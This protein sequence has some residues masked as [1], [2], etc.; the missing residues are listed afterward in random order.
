MQLFFADLYLSHFSRRVQGMDA[1]AVIEA[2]GAEQMNEAAEV[3]Y[4]LKFFSQPREAQWEQIPAFLAPVWVSTG[5]VDT[6]ANQPLKVLGLILYS[7]VESIPEEFEDAYDILGELRVILFWMIEL[8]HDEVFD[9]TDAED[10]EYGSYSPIWKV[11]RRLCRLAL[12]CPS[13]Q[14][15]EEGSLSFAYFLQTYCMPV[16]LEEYQQWTKGR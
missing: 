3:K 9:T 1:G 6:H 2:K 7:H 10:F 5:P 14:R 8:G 4:L 15:C 13:V 12:E 11:V 16:S